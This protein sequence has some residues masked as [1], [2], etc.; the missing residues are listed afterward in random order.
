MR[1]LSEWSRYDY[2]VILK[3]FFEYFGKKDVISWLKI[4]HPKKLP[5]E[6]L[7][8]QEIVAMVDAAMI[9]RDKALIAMLFEGGFRIGELMTLKTK[10]G[11]HL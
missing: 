7:T 1:E 6:I 3:T 5:D 11:Y 10:E 2:E 9:L 8:E 4:K